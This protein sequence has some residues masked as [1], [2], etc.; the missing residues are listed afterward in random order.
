VAHFFGTK[1]VHCPVIG[2]WAARIGTSA[3]EFIFTV[4]N[5]V[6]GFIGSITKNPQFWIQVCA[7]TG[8]IYFTLCG[9]ATQ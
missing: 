9:Y 2:R 1:L 4:V 6:L 8:F 5:T 3:T 7:A